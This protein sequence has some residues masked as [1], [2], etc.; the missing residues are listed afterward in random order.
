MGRI[1]NVSAACIPELHYM[2]NMDEK[3]NQIKSMVDKGLYFTINR[4]RQYGKTTILHAL[5]RLLQKEYIVISL[6]FQT[7]SAADFQTEKNFV[8]NFCTEILGSVSS[9]S[10]SPIIRG[11]LE[12]MAN[13]SVPNDRLSILF[14][15][16]SKWCGLSAQKIILLI[17]ETDS[18]S[19]Y[20]VFIDFLAQLRGYYISRDKKPIFKSV[21]LA[22]VYDIKN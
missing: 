11:Q 5:E 1:F 16:L 7:F 21:V 20:Q 14:R 19:N 17:D 10:I 2:V 6:D 9:N 15:C 18:A 8:E 4:A 22:G 3:L 12:Q 13:N